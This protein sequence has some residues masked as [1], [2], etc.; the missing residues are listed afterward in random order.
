MAIIAVVGRKGGIG[1]STITG[2][3]AAEFDAMGLSVILVDAD[4]QHSLASWAAQGE[5]LLARCVQKVDRGRPEDLK[6]GAKAA[7]KA[8]DV[9][10]IDTPP[11]MPRPPIRLR[12]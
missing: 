4:P 7:N 9:V 11:G 3:L 8:V 6:A 10:L 1:K 5:G 2:N 12:W